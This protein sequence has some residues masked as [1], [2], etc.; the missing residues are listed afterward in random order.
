MSKKEMKVKVKGTLEDV[1]RHLESLVSSMKE[2]T[3]VIQKSNSF[4]T[5]KPQNIIS[6][7]IE[8]EQKKDKE[9]L[10]IEL[11]W[12]ANDIITEK[13]E[14]VLTISSREPEDMASGGED[15]A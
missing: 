8:G 3:V 12:K 4:I 14:P 15:E 7:E 5:L 9:E 13:H 10:K 1:C 6:L 11:S 2:G